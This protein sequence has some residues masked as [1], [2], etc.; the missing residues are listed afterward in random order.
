[1]VTVAHTHTLEH[2]DIYVL[3][4]MDIRIIPHRGW[5]YVLVNPQL[6]FSL[7]VPEHYS[8]SQCYYIG[9]IDIYVLVSMDSRR[10]H[11]RRWVYILTSPHVSFSMKLSEHY[12][13][14]QRYKW[15]TRLLYT[16]C[17]R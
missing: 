2:I 17:K 11:H 16:V 5:P 8:E 15:R 4:S 3:I 12:S 9:P 14:S 7:R 6:S 13:E 10:I 1:M